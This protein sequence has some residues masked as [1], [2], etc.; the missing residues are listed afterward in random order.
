VAPAPKTPQPG[1]VLLSTPE[2]VIWG[3]IAADR[4]PVLGVK[5]GDTVRID[6]VTHQGINTKDDPV[7]YFGRA[8]ISSEKVLPEAIEIFQKV[9]REGNAGPHLLTGPVRVDGARPGDMLEVRVLDVA[10]RVPY[11]VNSTG[12]G[13]GA[14]ADLL[15]E[16]ADKVIALDL[17]RNVALFAAG[18]EVPLAP[19]MGIVAVAPPPALKRVSTKPPGAFGGNIDF[20][21]I[22]AGA[23]LYL[24]VFN[25]GALF[26]TGDG[27]AC[28][29][30]GEVDGTAIEIS[31]T[32][33]VELIV[34]KEAGRAMTWP[35]AEDA[36][37]WYSMGMADT[38]DGALKEAIRETV[39]F[40]EHHAVP[41]RIDPILEPIGCGF[42]ASL[43]R[44]RTVR[45]HFPDAP[46]MMGIGNLTELTDCDSAG[47]NLLLLAICEEWQIGSILTTQVI[48]WAQSS[49]RE[50]DLA[51]RVVAYAI[52]N[53]VP[54]KR[55][56]PGL[57]MLRD[58]KVNAFSEAAIAQLAAS[59]KDHNYRIFVD[60]TKIHLVAAG[61]H[62]HGTDPFAMIDELLER[63]ESAN[64]DPS[65]AFYLGFEMSKALTALTVGKQ[66][67]QDV[68]LQ[69]GMLTRP[70]KHRRLNR[71]RR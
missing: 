23:T 12:P 24:P 71:K 17:Q 16:P 48:A 25:E 8:G 69:W 37:N 60:G 35:R 7:T 28:Q 3:W 66:Y 36:A 15:R 13:R 30:D 53:Q 18:V 39:A 31:L 29:G 32:P 34:H 49:V 20:K 59:I 42:A 61:V 40:L 68:A 19:F 1:A 62:L 4:A 2:T 45:Q 65:H 47:I 50:C 33:T 63:P 22:T 67:E 11:G 44:Y 54:P 43:N 55:L 5:S 10:I 38:L 26:Y 56:D 64:V 21:H 41:F 9:K 57:I 52:R 51:R 14:V 6:T 58:P 27:H 46:M 70:E